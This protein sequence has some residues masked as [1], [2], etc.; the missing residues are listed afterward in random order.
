MFFILLISHPTI[1]PVGLGKLKSHIYVKTQCYN[2]HLV[3][4]PK[5]PLLAPE[6][7]HFLQVNK[8]PDKQENCQE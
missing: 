4:S 7:K 2:K 3:H 8:P 5:L 6:V 1:Q